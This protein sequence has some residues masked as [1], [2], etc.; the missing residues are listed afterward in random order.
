MLPQLPAVRDSWNG[1]S[2]RPTGERLPRRYDHGKVPA[3]TVDAWG[4]ALW[5][6]R[7]DAEVRTSR[8]GWTAPQPR[9][10]PYDAILVAGSGSAV[11]EHPL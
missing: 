2:V 11:R 7:P 6:I 1:P 4:R 3:T 10:S 8:Y 5:L 9:T